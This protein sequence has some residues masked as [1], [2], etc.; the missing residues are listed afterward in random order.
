MNE[1][2]FLKQGKAVVNN[3]KDM[4]VYEDVSTV[5]VKHSSL[6]HQTEVTVS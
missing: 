1:D 4:G 5:E 6:A 3:A 2:Y